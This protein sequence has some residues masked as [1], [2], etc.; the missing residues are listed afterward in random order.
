M[1]KLTLAANSKTLAEQAAFDFVKTERPSFDLVSL[2][3]TM[4]LGPRG[5]QI[6]DPRTPFFGNVGRFERLLL[7][8]GTAFAEVSSRL[9]M[10]C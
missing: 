6:V 10:A 3:P 4:C 2:N 5:G 9:L 8:R 1:R 7:H